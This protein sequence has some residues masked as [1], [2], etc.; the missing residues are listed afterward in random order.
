MG[1]ETTNIAGNERIAL[2]M[3]IFDHLGSFSLDP[4]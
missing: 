1:Y 2:R 4:L 3:A